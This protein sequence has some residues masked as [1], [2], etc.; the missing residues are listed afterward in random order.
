[1]TKPVPCI[2]CGG[3][4]LEIKAVVF[5]A[6]HIRC[7]HCEA[8]GPTGQTPDEAIRRWN[9]HDNTSIQT[10]KD[11]DMSD[12][13]AEKTAKMWRAMRAMR[14]FTVNDVK[15]ISGIESRDTVYSYI[16]LM[17]Q[18][19]Y[20]RIESTKSAPGAPNVYRC[21][22]INVI[23]APGWTQLKYPDI[24]DAISREDVKKLRTVKVK[25]REGI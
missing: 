24:A 12:L 8:R 7:T 9:I 17:E 22:R 18:R 3:T 10:R 14:T 16:Y 4:Q 25:A 6:W 2:F 13:T 11:I 1:M 20:L 5:R 21:V 23:E 15:R 19:D